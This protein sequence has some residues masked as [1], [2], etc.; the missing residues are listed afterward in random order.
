M[1]N[2]LNMVTGGNVYETAYDSQA[3]YRAGL[4]DEEFTPSELEH[5]WFKDSIIV[6][7]AWAKAGIHCMAIPFVSN[8]YFKNGKMISHNDALKLIS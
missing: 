5:N 6:K 4:M 2:K 8:Q 1:E 3:L 7:G